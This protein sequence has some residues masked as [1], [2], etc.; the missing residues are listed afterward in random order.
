[1]NSIQSWTRDVVSKAY[2]EKKASF[3]SESEQIEWEAE[4][5]QY[6]EDHVIKKDL[7]E[8]DRGNSAKVMVR[9]LESISRR[10]S[11]I[12]LMALHGT[13]LDSIVLLG[14]ISG[15]NRYYPCW[16]CN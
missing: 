9:E 2:H 11:I 6:Y 4:M 8:V 16:L 13:H 5:I 14:Q 12:V 15:K 3:T 7:S 10:V 1:M